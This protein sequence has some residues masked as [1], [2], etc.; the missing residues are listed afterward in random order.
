MSEKTK[1]A[2]IRREYESKPL[3][4]SDLLSNPID[5][6]ET[7]FAQWMSLS[8]F[9]PTAMTLSTIDESG[10]P[11]SRVVLLKDIWQEQFV[12]YTNYHS[13]KGRQI[14]QNPHVALNFFWPEMYRQVRVKGVAKFLPEKK[15]DE[16]FAQRPFESQCSAL[17]SPQSEVIQDLQALQASL[18]EAEH[19]YHH[20][21]VPRP[22]HWGGYAIS[23]V[24]IEFWQGQKGRFHDRFLYR[25]SNDAWQILRLAP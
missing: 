7:W 20:Q 22:K 4:E 17:V 14:Q 15:S 24:E 11:D 25:R 9:E 12:F 16:Y 3:L 1:L 8:P 19:K 2:H 18:H 5:Q 6:F 13:A 21:S 23:P 10:F